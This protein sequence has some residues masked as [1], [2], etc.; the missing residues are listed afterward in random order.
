[1][2]F[3]VG[4]RAH[5]APIAERK[6]SRTVRFARN[7]GS[8]PHEGCQARTVNRLWRTGPVR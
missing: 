5:D 3:V 2:S 4:A 7:K 6:Q 8:P 1:M